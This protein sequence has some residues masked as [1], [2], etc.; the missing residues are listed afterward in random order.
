MLLGGATMLTGGPT[1]V[2][3]VVVVAGTVVVVSSGTLVVLFSGV[4]VVTT[5][6]VVTSVVLFSGHVQ[7]GCSGWYWHF[8]A[9][10]ELEKA[11][12]TATAARMM[13]RSA[14]LVM[15]S[16]YRRHGL[17]P[18]TLYSSYAAFVLQSASLHCETWQPTAV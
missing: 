11:M 16:L 15:P 4:V 5:V 17:V 8:H 10:A 12:K 1:S 14:R 7:E 2:G 13:L 9:D 18:A 6:V 3:T